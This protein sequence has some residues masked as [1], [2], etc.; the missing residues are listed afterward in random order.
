MHDIFCF[1]DIHGNRR[2]FD[3]V[4]KFCRKQDEECS[5]IFCGDAIDRGEDGYGIMKELLDDPKVVY[6][7]GNHE[8]MFT[9]AAREINEY[10]DF[11]HGDEARI[12][13]VLKACLG[14]DYKYAAIQDCLWNGGLPT[15]MDWI[16]DGKPM[17]IIE[18]VEKLPYTFST[19]WM[20]FCHSAGLYRTF[21][22]VAN[23]EYEGVTPDKNA[24]DDLIWGR[25]TL[26][27]GWAPKRTAVFGHT[28]VQHLP[29][30]VK[31]A[32]TEDVLPV[33]FT[34]EKSKL[35]MFPDQ[36]GS[37]IDLDVGTASTKIIYVLNCMTGIAYGF[38][39][40][41]DKVEEIEIIS[42]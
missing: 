35:A 36:T 12:R 11:S 2:L 13:T 32:Y 30:Y 17:D 28:P 5:F 24:V 21:E 18:R 29:T 37:K 16:K 34:G 6:L 22:M 7:K 8:D 20:D 23:A 14:F 9:K 4:M 26:G 33:H 25:N 38:Q 3:A 19:E 31:H 27:Y 10:F 41:D 15:L 42:F 40:K 1:T 39:E